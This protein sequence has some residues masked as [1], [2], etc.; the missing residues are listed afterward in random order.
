MLVELLKP[1]YL[2]LSILPTVSK[3]LIALESAGIIE[4]ES[5]HIKNVLCSFV[6]DFKENLINY[7]IKV[8]LFG[9]SRSHV[10]LLVS[11]NEAEQG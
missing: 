1:A 10:I 8:F 6:S 11:F 9:L 7:S 5:H 2:N 3:C 4:A